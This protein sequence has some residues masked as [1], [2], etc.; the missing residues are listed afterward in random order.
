M[1][2]IV[3]NFFRSLLLIVQQL[4]AGGIAGICNMYFYD[5][6]TPSL[7]EFAKFFGSEANM[8]QVME[9]FQRAGVSIT[10]ILC[11]YV[12]IT[13][14]IGNVI[15]IKDTIPDLIR[16]CA[17]AIIVG[18][19]ITSFAG[20]AI[21]VGEETLTT[22]K[23]ELSTIFGDGVDENGKPKLDK[24]IF[25]IT[26]ESLEEQHAS[27]EYG[28]GLFKDVD[29][30]DTASFISTGVAGAEME[31][32][33]TLVTI[34]LDLLMLII[35]IILYFIIAY[36]L[37]KLIVE[38]VR[39]YVV[40]GVLYLISPMMPA[41]LTTA[42][43]AIIFNTYIKMFA[44][45]M[46]M[47]I[48]TSMWIYISM[49]AMG[50]I[51]AT[52]MGT[53]MLIAF[54]NIGIRLEGLLRDMGFSITGQGAA[55]LDSV[56]ATGFIMTRAMAGVA[57]GAGA[58]AIT[59][60]SA[61]GSV[62]MVK[63]GSAM[64]GRPVDPESLMRTMQGNVGGAWRAGSGAEL[65]KS[66][67]GLLDQLGQKSFNMNQGLSNF[68]ASNPGQ[69][70]DALQHLCDTQCADLKGQLLDKDGLMLSATGAHDNINGIGVQLM[71]DFNDGNGAVTV[72]GG[73]VSDRARGSDS[74]AFTDA[75]GNTRYFN[76]DGDC[77]LSD[78]SM[79][80][81][82]GENEVLSDSPTSGQLILGADFDAK[83]MLV[84]GDN[85]LSHYNLSKG[86][87]DGEFFMSH[88]TFEK[89]ISESQAN[90]LA[91]QS[92]L[93]FTGN[94]GLSSFVSEHFDASQVSMQYVCDNTCSSLGEAYGSS[95]GTG[96]AAVFATGSYDIE[97]GM[98]VQMMTASG[99]ND[100]SMT[101]R[102][103]YV[104]DKATS[105]DSIAFKTNNGSTS[106][107]N[108]TGE[109]SSISARE[110]SD[111]HTNADRM[112][113]EGYKGDYASTK[114]CG[115]VGNG[116][117][118][119]EARRVQEYANSCKGDPN[120]KDYG[121][122]ILKEFGSN[123]KME[124]RGFTAQSVKQVSKT[125]YIITGVDEGGREC[126]KL[127]SRALDNVSACNRKNTRNGWRISD[128]KES[129]KRVGS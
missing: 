90:Y 43:S 15:E 2:E 13:Y 125:S 34:I 27:G 22:I 61:A 45:Q 21:A 62:G 115:Y 56:V 129:R 49:Y 91:S 40:Y 71:K 1:I 81:L 60:G 77:L 57:K 127:M 64:T 118:I 37:I 31:G 9:I 24:M 14:M 54:I 25:I 17:T 93:G 26:E 119:G 112:R 75:A 11:V 32:A 39:R 73:Y 44:T 47:V 94:E 80:K 105:S 88:D 72:R 107:F 114:T 106:Y 51:P 53:F 123:G 108:P 83:N 96:E 113:N 63:F 101:L 59:A 38:L 92:N 95:M 86:E 20:E 120:S 121:K 66:Q 33:A 7:D 69:A 97:K 122:T 23:T 99:S 109:S 19:V 82:G 48:G 3:N 67:L 46:G 89:G 36:N 84:D 16:R 65:T 29:F 41:F 79:V 98:G 70:K 12:G 128:Y 87:Q 5:Q 126:K 52:L 8:Q 100:G 18:A 4:I 103:G 35:H 116:I 104:S 102:N 42:D 6:F 85:N 50:V 124:M 30:S 78:T 28:V 55:L 76:P 111:M 10:F 74:M 58:A 110:A 68:L 117:K